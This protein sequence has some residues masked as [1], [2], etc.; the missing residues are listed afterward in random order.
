MPW[1]PL[2]RK[3]PGHDRVRLGWRLRYSAER[4]GLA[5]A[6]RSLPFAQRAD[7]AAQILAGVSIR[8]WGP[9]NKLI[10]GSGTVLHRGVS[11]YFDSPAAVV[12]IGD[13]TYLNHGTT[14]HC[15]RS[16][17]I[18]RRCAIAW[19]VNITDSDHHVIEA[20]AVPYDQPVVIG[21]DV[22]VGLGAIILK[23]VTIGDGAVIAAGAVV[24]RDVPAQAL[25]AGC[26]AATVKEGVSW[27]P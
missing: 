12:D 10:L 18:G 22:W 5:L 8:R 6:V 17:T 15:R 21:D 3:T 7:A 2:P 19:G 25:V 1:W 11:I 20:G 14:L 16:I 23:G 13:H 4:Q 27:R 24:T 9:A 26:P